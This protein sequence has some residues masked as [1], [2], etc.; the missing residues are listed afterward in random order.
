M[1]IRRGKDHAFD[2]GLG[3]QHAIERI[4]VNRW[5]IQSRQGVLTR[6]GKFMPTIVDESAPKSLRLDVEIFAAERMLDRHFPKAR[7]TEP[8]LRAG[9]FKKATGLLGQFLRLACRPQQKV[10]VD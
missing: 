3:D 8:Y 5:Q 4:F 2:M 7:R 1:F 6:D 9:I 10:G